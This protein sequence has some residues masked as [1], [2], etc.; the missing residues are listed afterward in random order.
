MKA[1]RDGVAAPAICS[2]RMVTAISAALAPPLLLLSGKPVGGFGISIAGESRTGK[3]TGL[4]LGKSIV[5][6]PRPDSWGLSRSGGTSALY[7]Y[8]D[9]PVFFDETAAVRGS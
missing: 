3:T 8:T 7:G 6:E 5:S 4:R 2:S 1:W 9:L